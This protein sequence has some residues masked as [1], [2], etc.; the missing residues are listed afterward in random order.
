MRSAASTLSKECDSSAVPSHPAGSLRTV[1]EIAELAGGLAHELRNPLSTMM[2]NLKL[3]SEELE[4]M[5]ARP[6][7]VRRRSL[8][9]VDVLRR[10]AER[11]QRL[12]DE[13]LND[14]QFL[15]SPGPMVG[16]EAGSDTHSQADQVNDEISS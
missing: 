5:D 1:A 10:E 16:Q 14:S 9:K 8:L 6:E 7:D 3:L 15:E 4:D 2:I 13:F 12:F 11:L